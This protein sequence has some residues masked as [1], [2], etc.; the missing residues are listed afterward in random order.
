MA[1]ETQHPYRLISQHACTQQLLSTYRLLSR[2]SHCVSLLPYYLTTLEQLY[3][4]PC[5]DLD[6][7]ENALT[8]LTMAWPTVR[9]TPKTGVKT[10]EA[11]VE[12]PHQSQTLWPESASV[13][14]LSQLARLNIRCNTPMISQHASTSGATP[15]LYRNTPQHQVQQPYD[16]VVRL[17]FKC[18]TPMISWHAS[19]LGAI[20]LTSATKGAQ[21]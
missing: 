9:A 12:Q 4:N 14:H 18:N 15:L 16:I 19:L 20:P 13:P 1:S 17:D 5:H 8:R 21:H 10:G 6:K 3:T 7:N 2:L 11:M